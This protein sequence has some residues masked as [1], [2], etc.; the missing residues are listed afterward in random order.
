MAELERNTRLRVK[1]VEE[2]RRLWVEN[3]FYRRSPVE[4][5]STPA[6]VHRVTAAPVV[7]VNPVPRYHCAA[8][9]GIAV[10]FCDTLGAGD[11]QPLRLVYGENA[12]QVDTGDAMPAETDVVIAIEQAEAAGEGEVIIRS[13]VFPWQNVLKVGEDIVS[14]ELLLPQNRRLRPQDVGALLAAGALELTVYAR[15]RVWIQPTGREA[16][17]AVRASETALGESIELNG[18]VLSGMVERCGGEPHLQ[19]PVKDGYESIKMRLEGA[20]DSPAD[21]V[22]V[23]AGLSTC[24]R[25]FAAAAM[26]DLGTVLVDGVAMAPGE[27]TILGLVR[28]KPVVGVSGCPVSAILAFEEFVRPLLYALQGLAAPAFSEA[29]AILGRRAQSR[30]GLEEFLRVILGRVKGRLIA[31]PLQGGAGL[32]TS[33]TRTDGIVRIPQE[34]VGIDSGEEVCVRLLRPDEELDNNLIVVGSHDNTIDV[35][36][37]E[38]K[39]RDSRVHLSSSNVGSLA[40]LMAIRRGQAHLAGCHL[41][42]PDTGEYNY[43]YIARY[44][45][46]I[47]VRL[48]RLAERPQGLLVRSGNPK[49]ITGLKDLARGDVVFI[50][51]Q[52]GAGTRVLLDHLLENS[53]VSAEDI[54]G[55]DREEYTH[56]AVAVNVLSGRADAGMAIY[57]S[58]KAVGLDFIPITRERYD[59][60]I[61]ESSWDDP[62]IRLLLDI[63]ASNSFREAATAKGGYDLRSSGTILGRWDGGMWRDR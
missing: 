51:R 21:V 43:S 23:D 57:A 30:Q 7:A 53:G 10:R 61:P 35:L 47:P 39:R 24:S 42:D 55:Y 31:M 59:L 58:A 27:S 9:K 3:V 33:L 32:I 18:T 20:V 62:K 36:A 6:A 48:V 49:E 52:P 28:G 34:L 22:L 19:E 45:K 60:V 54:P 15:P 5:I 1:T 4:K 17:P 2:A 37:N 11:L 41:L 14:G 26:A 38:L 13:A 25:D 63:I 44:L 8:V 50:N 29:K 56:M 46:G 12:F 16:A 40:G